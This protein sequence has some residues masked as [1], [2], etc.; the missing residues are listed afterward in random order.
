MHGNKKWGFLY[1]ENSPISSAFALMVF[2]DK[3]FITVW[4]YSIISCMAFD[5]T[6]SK[7][8]NCMAAERDPLMYLLTE[9]ELSF[10]TIMKDLS[11]CD[12]DIIG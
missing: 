5:I 10:C 3:E 6:L 1:P 11:M 7:W 9:M 4:I 8:K 2:E 12:L